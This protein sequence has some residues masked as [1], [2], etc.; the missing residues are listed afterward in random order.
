[1]KGAWVGKG[2]GGTV[3]FGAQ[4]ADRELNKIFRL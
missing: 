4:N 3:C 2:S 1:M